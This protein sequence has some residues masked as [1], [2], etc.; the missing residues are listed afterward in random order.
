VPRAHE[1]RFEAG[2]SAFYTDGLVEQRREVR[3]IGLQRLR[4]EIS[5]EPANRVAQDIMRHVVGD[6]VP[7]DDI[8]L[9]VM[10]RTRGSTDS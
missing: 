5:P 8:A 2:V 1:L 4:Q 9:I 7:K 10:R 3:D 6:M